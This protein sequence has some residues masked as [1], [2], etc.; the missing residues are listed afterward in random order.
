[1]KG[2]WFEI[3]GEQRQT[4]PLCTMMSKV[5]FFFFL[6]GDLISAR[7]TWE[8]GIS[9]KASSLFYQPVGNSLGAFSNC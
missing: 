3:Q 1:M 4:I 8:E 7:V 2:F 6:F 9:T 5:F